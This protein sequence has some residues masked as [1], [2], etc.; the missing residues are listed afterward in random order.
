ML[1]VLGFFSSLKTFFFLIWKRMQ[2]WNVVTAL[3]CRHSLKNKPCDNKCRNV[4]NQQ[5]KNVSWTVH[6]A[7]S[8]S[9][10]FCF[11]HEYLGKCKIVYYTQSLSAAAFC[12]RF[13]GAR[14]KICNN[15]N[16]LK[17]SAVKSSSQKSGATAYDWDDE[18]Q[19]FKRGNFMWHVIS[20]ISVHKTL[21]GRLTRVNCNC[22]LVIRNLQRTRR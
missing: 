14:N 11:S 18:P 17:Q 8:N 6:W 13:A 16:E 12:V 22:N 2:L 19:D 20:C 15:Y 5:H 9:V 10:S 4:A 1:L 7:E 3:S 21:C